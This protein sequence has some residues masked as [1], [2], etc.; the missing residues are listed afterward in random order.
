M[1]WGKTR[2]HQL[3]HKAVT[4]FPFMYIMIT[5][6]F[7][8]LLLLHHCSPPPPGSIDVYV[9]EKLHVTSPLGEIL[10]DFCHDLIMGR[11]YIT[12]KAIPV[13]IH[14]LLYMGRFYVRSKFLRKIFLCNRDFQ[15]NNQRVI[16]VRPLTL[17][18][19]SP[20]RYGAYI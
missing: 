16:Y 14:L 17:C 10:Y 9:K 1:A 3:R 2:Y 4:L 20:D 13:L 6:T 18:E 7:V 5:P 15:H 12:C 8:N 11:F 19:I